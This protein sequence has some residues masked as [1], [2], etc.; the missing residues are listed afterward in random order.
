MLRCYWANG[1]RGLLQ[2]SQLCKTIELLICL[3]LLSNFIDLSRSRYSLR[4]VS[5]LSELIINWGVQ[6]IEIERVWERMLFRRWV[7]NT[8]SDNILE[9]RHVPCTEHG[10]IS[11]EVS[12]IIDRLVALSLTHWQQLLDRPLMI[13]RLFP[14]ACPHIPFNMINAINHSES[15]FN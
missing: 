6:I 11:L 4:P 12:I 15:T 13:S 8:S 9:L 3:K 7:M 14:L 10:T 5:F 2:L 1:T